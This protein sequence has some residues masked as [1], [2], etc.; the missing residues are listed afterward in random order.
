MKTIGY[1]RVSSLKQDIEKNRSEILHLA[2]EKDLGRVEW[3]EEKISGK[4]GWKTRKIAKVVED[5]KADD[6]LIVNEL[7]RLGRNSLEIMEILSIALDKEVNV[8]AI[9]GNWNLDNSLQSKIIA[10]SF[11]IA[12]EIERDLISARTKEALKARKKAGVILGRPNGPGK[13]KLDK[14]RPE[15]EA[16]YANGSTQKFIAERYDTTP[17]NLHAY[18]K[19]HDIKKPVSLQKKNRF[20]VVKE[21]SF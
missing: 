18:L 6:N 5:L 2:N 12:A 3:I 10:F 11:A 17:G 8:Y 1:L 20:E 4:K 14:Y 19:K 7:S 15:I 9:K 13:S 21:I 16:L